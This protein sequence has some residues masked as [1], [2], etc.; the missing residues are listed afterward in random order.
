MDFSELLPGS[1]WKYP[2]VKLTTSS[3]I[4]NL[5]QISGLAHFV[6]RLREFLMQN[7]YR[8]TLNRF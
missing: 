3:K 5:M 2:E 4:E 8:V 1:T 7:Y 6:K